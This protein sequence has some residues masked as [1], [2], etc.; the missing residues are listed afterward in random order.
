MYVYAANLLLPQFFTNYI[1]FVLSQTYSTLT[2]F[3]IKYNSI[4]N[5]KFIWLN[6]WWNIFWECI[7]F[8]CLPV[9]L[10]FSDLSLQGALCFV[11]CSRLLVEKVSVVLS[12][13][14]V[15]ISLFFSPSNKNEGK[16][17]AVLFNKKKRNAYVGSV[18]I[19]IFL[20]KF[21]QSWTILFRT[22]L[23]RYVRKNQREYFIF[24][25]GRSQEEP[26]LYM[27]LT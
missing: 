10:V 22:N 20:K 27:F 3:K 1:R 26:Y 21:D 23:I 24:Q 18:N 5:A 11:F 25:N 4:C 16:S 15:C 17:L 19:A 6:L 7:C 8:H 2:K 9:L 14:C 12:W 13:K